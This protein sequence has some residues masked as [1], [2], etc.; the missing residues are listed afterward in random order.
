ME[1]MREDAVK[2]LTELL[3]LPT[4]NSKDD[5]GALAEYLS[6]YFHTHGIRNRVQRIDAV[7]GNVTAWI[8][9]EDSSRTILLN[10]HL[11]TV[12]YGDLERWK[13]DP[14][15]A[16]QKD[17]RIYARGVSD[18]KSGLGAMVY[19]M[20]HLKD[21]PRTNIQFIG[22][23][24]EERSGLGAQ[25]ILKEALLMDC[26]FW[27]I[28]EP[29]DLKLGTAHK[30]CLWLKLIVRG[31]TGHG[32]YPEK[33]VNAIHYMYRIA[34][35][36]KNYVYG[37]CHPLLGTATAQVDMIQG[38]IAPNMTADLCEAVMDIRM[39]PGLTTEMIIARGTE[40]VKALKKEA[41]EL[42]AEFHMVNNRRAFE[43][44]GEE[45][46]VKKLRDLLVKYGYAGEEIG[47]NF[48]TDASV[49]AEKDYTRN[50]LLFG[51]GNPAMAHQPDEY[52]EV[53]KYLD[54][55]GILKD[56]FL[57]LP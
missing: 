46:H 12:P 26:D 54:A 19:A 16:V 32:A 6:S 7:H 50:V 48:F 25:M 9:G 20:T 27:L 15:K 30:G 2:L 53:S 49:L 44:D 36:I 11:D 55:I 56:L 33:G 28:G 31:K 57:S 29:T 22:T 42:S 40:M 45:A 23:C 21:K 41:P 17:G 52:V 10:G 4:V 35:D 47:I 24:D 37:F 34:E 14:A 8:E 3:E 39:V 5:E 18:M 1:E 43:I 51:P 38:G 13:T